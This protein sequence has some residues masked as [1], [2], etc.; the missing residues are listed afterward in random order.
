MFGEL[1]GR[2]KNIF[3]MG[4]FQSDFDFLIAGEFPW[5]KFI[6]KT[7]AEFRKA[8]GAVILSTRQIFSQLKET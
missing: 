2:F 8:N 3:Q 1:F 4:E 5:H 6:M 7:I